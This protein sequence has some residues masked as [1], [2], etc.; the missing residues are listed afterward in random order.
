VFR[1]YFTDAWPALEQMQRD[2]LIDLDEASIAILPAGR[3]LVHAVCRLFDR[4]SGML[5]VQSV[6]RAV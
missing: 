3:L 1:E 4:Y 5:P 2:G 6:S